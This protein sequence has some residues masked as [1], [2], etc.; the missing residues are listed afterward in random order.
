MRHRQLLLP[1]MVLGFLTV[2][3][4]SLLRT[5]NEQTQ[6]A[7]L[8]NEFV[9]VVCVSPILIPWLLYSTYV[10]WRYPDRRGRRAI[11]IGRVLAILAGIAV[12]LASWI[13]Y[14]ESASRAYAE[15]VARAI[16][17]YRAIHKQYPKTLEQVGFKTRSINGQNVGADWGLLYYLDDKGP[18]LFYRGAV[19]FSVNWYE[20]DKG[21]WT[22]MED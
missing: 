7:L 1:W 10:I 18:S 11:Q 9:G 3:N 2:A 20:F 12:L 6:H 4:A 15:R 19:P 21:R 14:W 5:Q 22:Y 8:F 16:E 17:S 13:V